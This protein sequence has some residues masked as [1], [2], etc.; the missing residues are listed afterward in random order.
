M[1]A[2]SPI[3]L[4]KSTIV[5]NILTISCEITPNIL[6][7]KAK[8]VCE[9]AASLGKNSSSPDITLT[10]SALLTTSGRRCLAVG[11]YSLLIT[12]VEEVASGK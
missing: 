8:N 7:S 6:F 2:T 11:T 1:R 4:L 5:P 12:S 10:E 3:R 9:M